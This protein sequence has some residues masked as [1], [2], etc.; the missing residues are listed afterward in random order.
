M[1]KLEK[2]D[3]KYFIFG[4]MLLAA[5]KM[6][7]LLDR[8]LAPSDITAKQWFLT[9]SIKYLFEEPPTLNELSKAMGNS[10]QNVKQVALKL[11]K[12]GFLKMEKDLKDSRAI[13][14]KLTEKNHEFWSR[15]PEGPENFLS[16]IFSDLSEEEMVSFMSIL[17]KFQK[18]LEKQEA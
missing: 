15:N 17:D 8:E 13:R 11:E 1:D 6:Q 10:H 7:T 12:K 18:S 14:L 2:L 3:K 5:N 16:R 4:T 9:S